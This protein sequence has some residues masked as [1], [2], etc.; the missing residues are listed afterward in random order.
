MVR[1]RPHHRGHDQRRS[2]A[3]GYRERKALEAAVG[4]AG[5]GL[6]RIQ[7]ATATLL[8]GSLHQIGNQLD[9]IRRAAGLYGAKLEVEA[10][11]PDRPDALWEWKVTPLWQRVHGGPFTRYDT[12]SNTAQE[13]L[14]TVHLVLAALLAAPDPRGRVLILDELGDSLGDEH[15]RHVLEAIRTT[16]ERT[17]ITVLGTCQD[18]VLS[19]AATHCGE[20]LYFEHVADTEALEP[21]N[22]DVRIR[23]RRPRRVDP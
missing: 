3:S 1:Q 7:D 2:R 21:S 11:R 17:G 16:A 22:S 9:E 10:V 20:I 18:S 19:D 6:E 14:F 12:R 23:P 4:E 8:E 13:K 15:R 5:E